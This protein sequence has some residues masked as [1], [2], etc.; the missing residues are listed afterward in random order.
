MPHHVALA[1]DARVRAAE[2]SDLAPSGPSSATR[3]LVHEIRNSL[4]AIRT[5]VELLQRRYRPEGREQRLF[6]VILTEIDRLS[7]LSKSSPPPKS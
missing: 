7:E 2:M 6:E 1:K 5:A 3:A 4:G